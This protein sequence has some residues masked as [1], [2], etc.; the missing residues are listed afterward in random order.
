MATR[1]RLGTTERVPLATHE[2]HKRQA[3]TTAEIGYN[4]REMCDWFGWSS[5]TMAFRY[6][7]AAETAERAKG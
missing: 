2:L 3:L 6:I 5:P 7:E 1:A 4:V